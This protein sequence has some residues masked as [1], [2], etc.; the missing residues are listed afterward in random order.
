[1][2]EALKTFSLQVFC[3]VET[4][5]HLIY[6]SAIKISTVKSQFTQGYVA[7]TNHQAQEKH[8]V[9]KAVHFTET[10][11]LKDEYDLLIRA[12]DTRHLNVTHPRKVTAFST[13]RL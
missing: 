1:M 7:P 13:M 6:R 8:G 12:F 9:K 5:S 10:M 11:R 2:Q 3:L 4:I